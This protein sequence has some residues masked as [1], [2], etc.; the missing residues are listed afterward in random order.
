MGGHGIR[1]RPAGW[2]AVDGITDGTATIMLSNVEPRSVQMRSRSNWRGDSVREAQNWKACSVPGEAARSGTR[3][4]QATDSAGSSC[5]PTHRTRR[6]PSHSSCP[7]P[8][9]A[10]PAFSWAAWRPPPGQCLRVPC[11]PPRPISRLCDLLVP[12]H[13]RHR[14]RLRRAACAS[15]PRPRFR[16]LTSRRKLKGNYGASKRVQTHS[17]PKLSQTHLRRL[18][19]HGHDAKESSG[20]R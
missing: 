13:H 5:Q 11:P 19:A 14:H 10:P 18:N 4:L 2:R 7:C 12:G 20:K 8:A 3:E 9:R 6:C 1:Q 16:G 17:G 15:T